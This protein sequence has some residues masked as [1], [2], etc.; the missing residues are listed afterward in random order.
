[1]FVLPDLLQLDL[2]VVFC[3]TAAGTQSAQAGAYYAGHGNRFW[4]TLF[5]IGLTP[6]KL[7]P[8]EFRSLLAYDVGLTDLVKIN[9]G[10]DDALR[11]IDFD[12]EGLRAKIECFAPQV[13]AFNGKRA[14]REFLGRPVEYGQQPEC[15]GMTTL[16]VL[17]ST[18]GA[19]RRWWDVSHW[20]QLARRVSKST[21]E[22]GQAIYRLHP[23][24]CRRGLLHWD[25]LR[26]GPSLGGAPGGSG[27]QVG[28]PT[29]AGGGGFHPGRPRLGRGP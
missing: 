15:L 13:L 18:S 1:M 12:I 27:L 28:R 26:F 19:A 9:C 25:D 16:F 17:P 14:A 29:A 23:I 20:E 11:A 21:D 24:L 22:G 6:Y 8:H 2:K 10:S 7:E 5:E 3:G 4:D